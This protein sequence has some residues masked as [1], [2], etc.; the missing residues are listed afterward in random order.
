MGREKGGQYKV[1]FAAVVNFVYK[2]NA[3]VNFVYTG[4]AVVRDPSTGASLNPSR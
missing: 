2:V 1:N 4:A 3:G